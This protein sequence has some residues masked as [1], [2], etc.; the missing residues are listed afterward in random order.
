MDQTKVDCI[1]PIFNEGRRVLS[2]VNQLRRVDRID[3]IICV[4]DGSTDSTS[5]ILTTLD[6]Y[7]D[8]VIVQ[9]QL[10]Q[11]KCAAVK[12]GLQQ[13]KQSLILL[14]DA[15]LQK[16]NAMEID[17]ALSLFL[18]RDQLDM[19]LFKRKDEVMISRIFRFNSVFTGERVLKRQDLNRVMDSMPDKYQLET[20][21]NYYMRKN[22]KSVACYNYSAL[23][24]HKPS[25]DTLF[26][27]LRRELEMYSDMLRFAGPAELLIQ[28]AFFAR[29]HLN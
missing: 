7:P 10:N 24:T 5:N 4:D 16:L 11:G 3:Q 6:Q 23:N 29:E 2:V 28:L 8:I 19:L 12:T 18:K 21:I 9:H 25:K 22:H 14:V 26:S 17:Q 13:T 20:A 27:A 15:D 1:I